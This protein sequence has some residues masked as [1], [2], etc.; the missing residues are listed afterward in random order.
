MWPGVSLIKGRQ[1][2]KN[3]VNWIIAF[4]NSD[5]FQRYKR[6]RGQLW[7][8]MPVYPTPCPPH[9]C[10]CLPV[11]RDTRPLSGEAE[12][13]SRWTGGNRQHATWCGERKEKRARTACWVL[14]H[15]NP[16]R[17]ASPSHSDLLV[18]LKQQGGPFSP[19]RK[20]RKGG[21]RKSGREGTSR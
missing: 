19:G 1:T 17:S 21:W 2:K 11:L 20:Q 13:H 18:W 4:K 6:G 5:L 15:H 16:S 8:E 3:T 14:T 7:Q 9:V 12:W 10:D